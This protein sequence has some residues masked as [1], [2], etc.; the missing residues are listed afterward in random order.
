MPRL[1]EVYKEKYS[2]GI[3]FGRLG[4]YLYLGRSNFTFCWFLARWGL[5][6]NGTQKELLIRTQVAI[7]YEAR[8]SWLTFEILNIYEAR[9]F[10]LIFTIWPGHHLK[11]LLNVGARLSKESREY[12]RRE[13]LE[14]ERARLNLARKEAEKAARKVKLNIR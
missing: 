8:Y 2:V 6:M 1:F 11:I 12:L 4:S 13:G 9:A 5:S 7:D 3:N 14:Q 10:Y